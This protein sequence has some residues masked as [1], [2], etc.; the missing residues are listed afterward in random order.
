MINLKV[1]LKDDSGASQIEYILIASLVAIVAIGGM[2]LV[3]GWVDGSLGSVSS[4][5]GGSIA[6]VLPV[7]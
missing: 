4:D 1:F 2:E 6:S 3:G 7:D 5:L